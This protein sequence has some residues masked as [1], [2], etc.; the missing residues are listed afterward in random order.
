MSK[1]KKKQYSELK[2]FESF[3]H[4]D[5]DKHVLSDSFFEVLDEIKKQYDGIGQLFLYPQ[6]I[7]YLEQ[8]QLA[9]EAASFS[10]YKN[11]N[12]I[13]TRLWAD[14]TVYWMRCYIWNIVNK[15]EI[16][17]GNKTQQADKASD[18]YEKMFFDMVK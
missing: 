6:V 5:D 10:D 16:R 11:P 18:K 9:Y 14:K 2:V 13:F 15:E 4:T 17:L 1:K 3:N 8:F 12:W 7:D